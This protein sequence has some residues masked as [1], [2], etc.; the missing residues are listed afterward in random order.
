MSTSI[1]VEFNDSN[2]SVLRP[3]SGYLGTNPFPE[4]DSDLLN[5]SSFPL[6]TGL[7]RWLWASGAV[8]FGLSPLSQLFKALFAWF[9]SL[10]PFYFRI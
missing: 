8:H 6:A 4:Q 10:L 3:S 1:A 2:I 9:A 5:F 7:G